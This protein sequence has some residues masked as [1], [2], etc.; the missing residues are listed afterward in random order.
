MTPPLYRTV[1]IY[2]ASFLLCQGAKLVS[3]QKVRPKRTEFRF[4]AN[5]DLHHQLRLYWSRE[6]VL[7]VPF[8]L[9]GSL[10]RLKCLAI[11]LGRSGLI[12]STAASGHH[13]TAPAGGGAEQSLPSVLP[14]AR[15][16]PAADSVMERRQEPEEFFDQ[17][18]P[19]SA[20]D[21]NQLLA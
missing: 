11:A 9:L 1:D 19:E 3:Y 14:G 15:A 20:Q 8:K 18:P 6:R 12:S 4:L 13:P 17:R 2:L 21:F 16:V 10:Y 5:E 7:V